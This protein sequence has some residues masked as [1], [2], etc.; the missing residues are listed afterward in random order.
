MDNFKILSLTE[1]ETV[2]V[3]LHRKRRSINTRQNRIVFRLAT[4]CGLRVS[5]VVGITL[6]NVRLACENPHIYVPKQI[7][8]RNKARKI[9][10]WWDA[11]TLADLAAWKEERIAQG[12]TSDSP[13]VCNQA[14]N[15]KFGNPLSIRNAQNRFKAAI[16]VLGSERV[17]SLSIHCGRHS[18]CSH[19]IATGKDIVLVRDA[20]GH[21][22]IATTNI[23]AH[24]CKD[25][26]KQVGNMFA[27]A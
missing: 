18:F 6:A 26:P 25:D 11:A 17:E 5:E 4:C 1:I 22:S 19:A 8:K 16:K 2:L 3:D 21:A 24:A 7:A 10:L 9:P 14:R 23:Y 15:E 20:A 12:A 13:F 27:S